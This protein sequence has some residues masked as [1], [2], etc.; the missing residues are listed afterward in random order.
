[1]E[2]LMLD[3][4]PDPEQVRTAR[5]FAAATARHFQL[6]E[7]RVEDLKVAISEAC[8]NAITSHAR[9]GISDP[10]T[11]VATRIPSGLRFAVVDRGRGFEPG[12]VLAATDDDR[13]A[14]GFGEGS[15]G[16]MLVRA[17]FPSLTIE[18]NPD[19]GMTVTITASATSDEGSV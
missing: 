13:A 16:L 9:A 15:L 8:T 6:D 7:E 14:S 1:M 11:I 17:L 3:I 10:V 12:P 4:P 19:R 2:E 5:L 18:R